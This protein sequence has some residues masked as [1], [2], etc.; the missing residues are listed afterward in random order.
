MD[1]AIHPVDVADGER[2]I[3]SHLVAIGPDRLAGRLH[4]TLPKG[5]FGR[6]TA[7]PGIERE[8]GQGKEDERWNCRRQPAEKIASQNVP[9]A[10]TA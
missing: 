1:D 6:V 8:C 5:G 7:G 4:P 3:E 9:P 10:S 2:I